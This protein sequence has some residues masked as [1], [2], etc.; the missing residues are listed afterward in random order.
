MKLLARD[1][2]LHVLARS[3]SPIPKERVTRRRL[4]KLWRRLREL[5]D[6]APGRAAP[7]L[8]LGAAKKE[9]GRACHLVDI[10][11]PA[12][13]EDVTAETFTFAL[14]R[15]RLREVRRREGRYLLRSNLTGEDPATPWCYYL[16]LTEVE[17]AFKELKH[18]LAVR[19]IFHQ[20]DE[21]IEAHIF[22]AY[23]SA[24]HPEE[25]RPAPGAGTDPARRIGEVRHP[26]DGGG[27][28][29]HHRRAASSAA[30][31]HAPTKDQ[32]LLLRQPDLRLP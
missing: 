21:R 20:L 19:P 17:Q 6:Q 32:Q 16:Q 26:A 5:R 24:H 4:K 9:A 22:V 8:K 11:L 18:D 31:A 29:S 1:G 14:R 3:R 30:A 15:D 27:A 23:L 10:R 25:P 13:D 2:E 7:L 12:A 28:P